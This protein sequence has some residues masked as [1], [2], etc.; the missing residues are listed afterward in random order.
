MVEH[1]LGC[2]GVEQ[3]TIFKLLI[4]IKVKFAIF[5]IHVYSHIDT[6]LICS[7][8]DDSTFKCPETW[9]LLSKVS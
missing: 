1:F 5:V 6:T 3:H 4:P 8:H 7:F 2:G 9:H